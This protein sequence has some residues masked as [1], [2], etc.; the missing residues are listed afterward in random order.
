MSLITLKMFEKLYKI[1]QTSLQLLN[2]ITSQTLTTIVLCIPRIKT[3]TK[4]FEIIPIFNYINL[5]HGCLQGGNGGTL[6]LAPGFWKGV[7]DTLTTTYIY[8]K[9]DFR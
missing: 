2:Y 6:L 8:T 4:N 1:R 3:P 9:I 7:I 5:A